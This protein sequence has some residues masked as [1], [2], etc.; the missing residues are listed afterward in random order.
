MKESVRDSHAVGEDIHSCG[1]AG[2]ADFDGEE[3]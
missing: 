2:L 3:A 1:A